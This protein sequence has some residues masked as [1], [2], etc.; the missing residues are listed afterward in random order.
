MQEVEVAQAIETLR[1]QGKDPSI[2]NIRK[3]LGHGSL[4]DVTK[5]RRKLL[6]HVGRVRPMDTT[7]TVEAPVPAAPPPT[8]VP[9]LVQVG[10]HLQAAQVA[11]RMA[12]RAYDLATDLQ[13]R[14]RCQQTWVAARRTREQA[15]NR[16]EQL[17][18]SHDARVAAIPAARVDARRAAGELA[19]A[20]ETARRMVLRAQRAAQQAQE[21]LARLEADVLAIAG[22]TVPEENGV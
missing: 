12:R 1:E 7:L 6:P 20:E 8:P 22:V 5:H 15:A 17:T 11:E 3:T 16:L 4:R 9:L 14:T 21:E 2:G 19:T 13:E 10:Q 18:R